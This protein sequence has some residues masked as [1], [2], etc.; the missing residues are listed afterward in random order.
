M[1]KIFAIGGGEIRFGETREIDRKIV[2]ASGKKNPKLLFIPTASREAEAYIKT[3]DEYFGGELGC[4]VE[5]LFLINRPVDTH[6]VRSEILDSDIIYVG[7]GNTRFMMETWRKHAVDKALREA[8]DKGIILSGL[9]AGSI[10]WFDCGQSDSDFAID[11]PEGRYSCVDGLGFIPLLH[12]P[13]HNEDHRAVDLPLL[14][15]E[16]ERTALALSNF[17]ALEISDDKCRFHKSSEEAYALKLE[18]IDGL[19]QE[20]SLPL[21]GT[22]RN[23]STLFKSESEVE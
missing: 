22:F 4:R 7:G 6:A 11:V 14:V 9:S 1:G 23:L 13:H 21:D 16:K 8:Y 18:V 2:E 17:C 19:I 3:V 20:T 5:T 10:C 12:A 15:R